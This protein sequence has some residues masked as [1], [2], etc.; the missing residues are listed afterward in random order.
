V[1]FFFFGSADRQLFGAYHASRPSVPERGAAV[2]CPPW[3]PE[4]IASHRVLRRLALM[5]SESGYHV[6]RF[7]YFGTGDSAGS[8]EEGDLDSWYA[9]A[10]AAVDELRD[11]SGVSKVTV[12]GIRLGAHVA[13]RLALNRSDVSAV[14]MWDPVIDG[15]E[16]VRELVDAQQ[17]IDRWSLVPD[18]TRSVMMD[19]SRNETIDLLGFPLTVAMRRTIEMITIDSYTLR[20]NARALLF[21]STVAPDEAALRTVLSTAGTHAAFETMIG[22]TP[23]RDDDPAGGGQLPFPLLTR[24][25]EM[26]S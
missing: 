17:E 25:V 13:W 1:N 14:V 18:D 15:T 22:Q 26:V 7:D 3:G 9:D 4:Y 23:W 6:L 12:F 2:L 19:S 16:Y 8:R 20:T 10:S 24:M 21:F 11:M 5:L